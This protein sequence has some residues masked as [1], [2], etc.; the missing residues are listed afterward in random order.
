MN[1]LQFLIIVALLLWIIM[2]LPP[3]IAQDVLM[4]RLFRQLDQIEGAITNISEDGIEEKWLDY[5]AA[6][7]AQH[8]GAPL[9]NRF[10]IKF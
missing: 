2:R 7:V 8:K 10:W 9:W 3:R 5:Q 4:R 6:L 1:W